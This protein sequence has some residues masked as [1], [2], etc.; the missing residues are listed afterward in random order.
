MKIYLGWF[1]PYVVWCSRLQQATYWLCMEFISAFSTIS[2]VAMMNS[3]LMISTGQLLS[4]PYYLVHC[5][6]V[7]SSVWVANNIAC[8]LAQLKVA[9][10]CGKHYLVFCQYYSVMWCISLIAKCHNHITALTAAWRHALSTGDYGFV[11]LLQRA[12]GDGC[13]SRSFQWLPRWGPRTTHLTTCMYYVLPTV[14]WLHCILLV[15]F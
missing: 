9:R 7:V 6:L 5:S 3:W 15:P 11:Q 12:V 14:Q 8:V 2:L 13:L 10:Y 4:S 1:F